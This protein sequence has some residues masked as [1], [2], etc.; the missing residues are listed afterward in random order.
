MNVADLDQLAA[1]TADA[2]QRL[3]AASAA[4]WATSTRPGP[5][6]A[7]IAQRF[8]DAIHPTR[9]CG[10]IAAPA[11][12]AGHA[13]NPGRIMCGPCSTTAGH[14]ITGTPEDTRCDGCGRT[15][16]QLTAGVT[17]VGPIA[18]AF[19][20]CRRCVRADRRPRRPHPNRRHTR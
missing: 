17:L 12:C 20:L 6:V 18:V 3:R 7:T 14:A 4:G 19:G 1:A 15:S 9:H 5:V 13:W 2:D 11:P 10:H 16:P 8:A